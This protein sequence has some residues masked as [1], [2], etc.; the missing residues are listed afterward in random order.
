MERLETG[1][2]A[3]RKQDR[4]RK[5]RTRERWNKTCRR[6]VARHCCRRFLC[7]IRWR[8][9]SPRT[10]PYHQ[11]VLLA[12]CGEPGR[13]DLP[14]DVRVRRSFVPFPSFGHSHK[15]RV[16]RFLF[17]LQ[18]FFEKGS[19]DWSSSGEKQ[20]LSPV[21]LPP[22]NDPP[23]A[24]HRESMGLVGACGR[25]SSSVAANDKGQ[26]DRGERQSQGNW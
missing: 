23:R 10:A 12:S 21:A 8:L 11:G 3:L 15:T 14:Q 26:T 20:C 16:T 4:N 18:P 13:E 19:C 5:R 7:N 2:E 25:S 17:M 1:S 9:W 24:H 22:V 6:Q